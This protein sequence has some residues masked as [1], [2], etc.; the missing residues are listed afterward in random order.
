MTPAG[1]GGTS[2]INY[3]RMLQHFLELVSIDSESRDE[4]EVARNLSEVMRELGAETLIDEAGEA[5]GG[6]S[7][8]LY[9]RFFPTSD[10]SAPLLLSAHMD[11]VVPGRGVK[12]RVVDGRVVTDGTTILGADDKSGCAVIAEVMRTIIENDVPHGNVEIAFTICEEQGLLGA[13]NFDVSR[14]DAKYGL[15]FDS[16]HADVIATAGPAAVRME[17]IVNGVESHAGVAPEAGI[18]AIAVAADAIG[19]MKLGRI[20]LET[21]ANIGVFQAT[22]ATNIVPKR[23]RVLGEARS[24]NKDKLESQ[25]AHMS[26]CFREAVARAGKVTVDGEEKAATLEEN[27]RLDYEGLNI[28]PGSPVITLVRQAAARLGREIALG[29]AGGGC[30]ANV[31]NMTGLECVNIG[32]GM[33]ANHTVNEW[34]DIAEFN[35]AADLLLEAIRFCATTEGARILTPQE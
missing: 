6:N 24:R 27:I 15:I 35:R 25:T 18:S 14:L 20:D 22:G 30:D 21:T 29:V 2:M 23:A 9:V 28:K 12:P 16:S 13:K 32:S 3:D 4:L 7:G 17:W 19:K 34:L 10:V 11:T 31:F 33:R 5:V 1:R 8:N 26:R